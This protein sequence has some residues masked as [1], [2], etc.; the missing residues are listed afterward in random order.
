MT[1]RVDGA[2]GPAPRAPDLAGVLQ[3]VADVARELGVDH[4]PAEAA[5]LGERLAEGRFFVACVGQFKRGKSTLLNALVGEAVLPTGVAPVTTVVTLLR[6]GARPTARVRL[7]GADWRAIDPAELP[8]YVTEAQNPENA[9]GVDAVEVFL[10]TPLLES[11]MCLVDTPGIGSVWAGNTRVT[12]AFV[13]HVDAALVVLGAD[14][15]I[16][17]EE[18]A[19]VQEVA[20]HTPQLVFVLNKA[21][22]LSAAERAEARRFTERVLAERLGRPPGPVFEVSAI[23]RLAGAAT[24]DWTALERTL[25]ALARESGRALVRAAA[26]RGVERLAGR[27][28]EALE[29]H[30]IALVRPLEESERRVAALRQ[31]VAEATRALQD[32]GPLFTAE[33]ERLAQALEAER[34]RFLAGAR[35]EAARELGQRVGAI[36]VRGRGA[37]RAEAL[38]QAREVARARLDAWRREFEPRAEAGYREAM[39]RFVALADGLV[40]RLRATGDPALAALPADLGPETAFR[41]PR[42]FAFADLLTVTRAAPLAWLVTRCAPGRVARALV[43]R[44]AQ[45]YLERLLATN[46]ARVVNDLVDRVVESRRGLEADIRARL[47]ETVGAAEHALAVA[48]ARREAGADA[49]GAELARLEALRRR[50]EAIRAE[51]RPG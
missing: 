16:S 5:A 23:E 13:P 35:P 43:R 4:L 49:V 25:G 11:G 8:R 12:R 3:T 22:R 46:S 44:D 50:I 30:R 48:R 31:A 39:A 17:G 45:A 34:R 32:L 7:A 28:L 47:R 10:P 1:R 14:P 15:P 41:V 9:K 33:Q 21:D 2:P 42:H 29:A 20:R 18:L 36:T 19:L 6:Y 37:L 40:S 38:A 27:L 51:A 26:E 24:R